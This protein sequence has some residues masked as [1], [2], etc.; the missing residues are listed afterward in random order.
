MTDSDGNPGLVLSAPQAMQALKP[1]VERLG[2]LPLAQ[3]DAGLVAGALQ[4]VPLR[5]RQAVHHV[6][7]LG[8]RLG[9]AQT[10][11]RLAL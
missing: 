2:Q 7:V 3:L 1:H 8:Q 5:P 4:Q 11:G 6:R 10:Q 9:T